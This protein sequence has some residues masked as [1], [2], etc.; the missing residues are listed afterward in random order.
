MQNGYI[1]S[2]VDHF[3]HGGFVKFTYGQPFS[4]FTDKEIDIY[5]KEIETYKE[6]IT[7]LSLNAP[8]FIP[9][10]P[11]SPRNLIT[12][13]LLNEVFPEEF[14]ILKPA[15]KPKNEIFKGKKKKFKR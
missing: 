2:L 14:P 11:N 9:S 4:F 1:L 6:V 15:I 7:D 5:L 12:E 10:A 8:P 3:I 13:E